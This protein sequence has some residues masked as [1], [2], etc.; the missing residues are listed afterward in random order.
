MKQDIDAP[1]FE[2]FITAKQ[3]M[4]QQ[5]LSFAELRLKNLPAYKQIPIYEDL[6]CSSLAK[7]PKKDPFTGLLR[8]QTEKKLIGMD[9]VKFIPFT[10]EDFEE[11]LYEKKDIEWFENT[12]MNHDKTQ[13][14]SN[15]AP[16]EKALLAAAWKKEKKTRREIA[17]LLYKEEFETGSRTIKALMKRVD[18]LL[19]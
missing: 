8:M 1:I 17:K 18:R 9:I 2:E 3:L 6:I 19:E 4:K 16:K 7:S 13:N 5:G 15:K 12:D 10:K 14:Y 11:A